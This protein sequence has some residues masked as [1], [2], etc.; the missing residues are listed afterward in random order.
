MEPEGS[1]TCPEE[2]TNGLYPEA[3]IRI[4]NIFFILFYLPTF[5]SSLQDSRQN[6]AG[7][8]PSYPLCKPI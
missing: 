4:I 1:L 7:I 8:S 6:T 2:L 3:Q 5:F